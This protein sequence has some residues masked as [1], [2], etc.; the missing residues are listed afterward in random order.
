M[1]LNDNDAL[2]HRILEETNPKLVRVP[3]AMEN[4]TTASVHEDTN[5]ENNKILVAPGPSSTVYPSA[6]R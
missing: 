3:G 4:G 1:T 2:A 6:A 5:T